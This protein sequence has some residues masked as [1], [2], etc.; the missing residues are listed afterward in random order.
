MPYERKVC[1]GTITGV[2]GGISGALAKAL[3]ARIENM[4]KRGSKDEGVRVRE[5]SGGR[6]RMC[7]SWLLDRAFI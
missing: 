3:R 6:L 5:M 4:V 1:I 7:R 2:G